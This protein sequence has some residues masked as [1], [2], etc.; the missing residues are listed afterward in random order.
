MF[1]VMCYLTYRYG[2]GV[3]FLWVVGLFFVLVLVD[4]VVAQW[5]G[6]LTLSYVTDSTLL[7]IIASNYRNLRSL[8]S[9]RDIVANNLLGDHPAMNTPEG[10]VQEDQG[11][12]EG[13]AEISEEIL[14]RPNK[15]RVEVFKLALLPLGHVFSLLVFWAFMVIAM[16]AAW[17]GYAFRGLHLAN[18]DTRSVKSF[19]LDMIDCAYFSAVTVSTIGYGLILPDAAPD[20]KVRTDCTQRM[21]Q[22]TWV[23]FIT[24]GVMLVVIITIIGT[25]NLT[26]QSVQAVTQAL[27]DS[28]RVQRVVRLYAIDEIK[29]PLV[30]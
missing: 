13:V 1:I 9:L 27:G 5:T 21:P 19:G 17:G 14:I 24:L 2:L 6:L 18:E 3:G 8:R 16:Q 26:F 25:F 20:E 7:A 23:R 4:C 10:M 22:T 15:Q 12:K 30:R 29:Y 28:D 11:F